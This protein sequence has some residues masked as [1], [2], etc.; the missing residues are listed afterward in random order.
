MSHDRAAPPAHHDPDGGYRNPWE[1]GSDRSFGKVLKWIWDR[2]RHGVPPNPDPLSLPSGESHIATPRAARGETR[3]TWVGHAT[4]L[5]QL[6]G[7]N[8]V[9][10]PHWSRRAAPVQ[11]LGP[12]RLVP[13]GLRLEDLPPLDAVVLSHDHYDHLDEGTV[14]SLAD[15][16]GDQL[17]WFTPLGYREW[18][19]KR[20]ARSVVELDWW[21]RG[22]VRAAGDEVVLQALPAQH[23]TKRGLGTQERL[24]ASWG[25]ES[26]SS[27]EKVYFGGDSGYFDG[28]SEIGAREGPFDLCLLPIGAYD[29]RWMMASNHMNPEEAVR[30]YRDLGGEG[31]FAAI[32]WGTFRLTDE[33]PLEPPV[34]ARLAWEEA[35]LPEEWL[36]IPKHG[37]TRVLREPARS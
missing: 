35:G 26:R 33:D 3:I 18:L 22:S 29:P 31:L 23:W 32:H 2:W 12:E 1:N 14:R 16:F 36:W 34:R 30:A 15:R 25:I 10:D 19:E 20:G 21:E 7:L 11:W 37:E 24:W 13:P 8:I 9:T 28:Y 5:I 6:G 27:G 4:T 17:H